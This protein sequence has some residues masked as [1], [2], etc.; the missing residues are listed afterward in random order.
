MEGGGIAL[1]EDVLTVCS[2]PHW[3]GQPP[4]RMARGQENQATCRLSVVNSSS[5]LQVMLTGI[6]ERPLTRQKMLEGTSGRH[7]R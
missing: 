2:G 6:Y 3:P 4:H 7:A 1:L 5:V